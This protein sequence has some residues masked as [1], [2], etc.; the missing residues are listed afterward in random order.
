MKFNLISLISVVFMMLIVISCNQDD[1]PV[2]TTQS[3]DEQEDLMQVFDVF[4]SSEDIDWSYTKFIVLSKFNGETL[5]DT[6]GS[7]LDIKISLL[8]DTNTVVNATVGYIRDEQFNFISYTDIKSGS[9]LNLSRTWETD[10]CFQSGP[11]DRNRATLMIT[12]LDHFYETINPIN[13]SYSD[14]LTLQ[15]DTLILEGTASSILSDAQYQIAIREQENSELKSIIIPRQDW[16][17]HQETQSM[18]HTISFNDFT[19]TNE[20]KVDL[21]RS[22]KWIVKVKVCDTDG[23]YIATQRQTSYLNL[24]EGNSIIVYLNEAIEVNKLKLNIAGTNF[25]SGYSYNW[26][27]GSIPDQIS[28][29]ID[30]DPIFL[31]LEVDEYIIWNTFN[32]NLNVLNYTYGAYYD[33]T[34]ISKGGEDVRFVLPK[35]PS[36]IFEDFTYLEDLLNE[37]RA[38][39]NTM[40]RTGEVINDI[41][42]IHKS[43]VPR[44]SNNDPDFD[45]SARKTRITL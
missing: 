28:F 9:Q 13:G 31:R 21:D 10:P 18:S 11:V 2:D 6:L 26:I 14:S 27:H 20:Y 4:F 8:L 25:P 23:N 43:V 17:W 39:E 16:E 33:W 42:K 34:I 40:Y 29:D 19:S 1:L 22:D 32:Y 41:T 5:Y 7:E 24:K 35:V 44:N 3:E 45:Y 37:P 15:G 30:K 12:D 38:V 36:Q